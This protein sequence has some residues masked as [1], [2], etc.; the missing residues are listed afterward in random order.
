MEPIDTRSDSRSRFL[1]ATPEQVFAAM[2]DPER[3]AR[4]WG[5]DGFTNTIHQFDFTVGG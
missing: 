5:P 3:V 2:S 1:S 4:W